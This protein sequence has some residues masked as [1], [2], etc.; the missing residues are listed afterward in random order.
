MEIGGVSGEGRVEHQR[1]LK[2]KKLTLYMLGCCAIAAL[3]SIGLVNTPGSPFY[4]TA[5]GF[6]DFFI[7]ICIDTQRVT[8]KLRV[9]S[10]DKHL[11]ITQEMNMQ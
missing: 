3:K 6:Q 10:R 5:T 11:N 7:F 1:L 4:R 2:K 9:T 8:P